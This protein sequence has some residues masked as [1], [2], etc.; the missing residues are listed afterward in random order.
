M[1]PSAQESRAPHNIDRSQPLHQNIRRDIQKIKKEV[2]K[3]NHQDQH[4]ELNE[5]NRRLHEQNDWNL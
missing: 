2:N 4:I 5:I 3:A 1:K